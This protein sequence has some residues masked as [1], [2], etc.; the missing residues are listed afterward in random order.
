MDPSTCSRPQGP[1]APARA[2][3]EPGLSGCRL[4]GVRAG[5]ASQ[6]YYRVDASKQATEDT[7][8]NGDTRAPRLGRISP[9]ILPSVW[10]SFQQE[11]GM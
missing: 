11:S 5:K 10:R 6:D 4:H 7:G 9:W 2:E 3:E 8:D 1:R